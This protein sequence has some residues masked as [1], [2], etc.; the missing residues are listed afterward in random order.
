VLT[1]ADYSVTD[2]PKHLSAQANFSR[3]TRIRRRD[4]RT[5]VLTLKRHAPPSPLGG[6][7]DI[8]HGAKVKGW[9][10]GAPNIDDA[11]LMGHLAHMIV[12]TM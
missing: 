3:Q 6:K 7:L 1:G 2:Q 5:T 12:S 10:T 11:I 9:P 4:N 8:L